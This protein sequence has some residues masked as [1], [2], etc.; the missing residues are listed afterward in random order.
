MILLW[1]SHC[2][3]CTALLRC[4]DDVM[5]WV[6][7]KLATWLAIQQ[8][9]RSK[10]C[11]GKRRLFKEDGPGIAPTSSAPQAA[12]LPPRGSRCSR[13][14]LP[15]SHAEVAPANP[16]WTGCESEV[17]VWALPAV[18]R[19]TVDVDRGERRGD[20][21][22]DVRWVV[23]Q[24]PLVRLICSLLGGYW[25][26]PPLYSSSQRQ[27]GESPAPLPFFKPTTI[28]TTRD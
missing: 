22:D 12:W 14:E 9:R 13:P 15:P 3:T 18:P 26:P 28:G 24:Q 19:A 16:R 4:C 27:G 25:A 17:A 7:A 5:M 10:T 20:K 1:M 8:S 23:C 2:R 21:S 11:L 6:A